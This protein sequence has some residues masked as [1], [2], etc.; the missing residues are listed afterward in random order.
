MN[1]KKR[2]LLI[3]DDPN[4]RAMAS[5]ILKEKE[6]EVIS[7]ATAREAKIELKQGHFDLMI[8][9]G[10]LPDMD[11][12]SFI[13]EQRKNEVTTPVLFVSASWKDSTSY[14]K[15]SKELGVRSILHKPVIAIVLAQEVDKALG[16]WVP[17]SSNKSQKIAD[18]LEK[19]RVQYTADLV[20]RIDEVAD[21]IEKAK[22][23]R[24]LQ[25]ADEVYQLAHKL[26]GTGASFGFPLISDWMQKIE[27]QIDAIKTGILSEAAI[28]L[29]WKDIETNIQKS[30]DFARKIPKTGALQPLPALPG[31]VSKLTA[32]IV[33]EDAEVE[34]LIAEY[35]NQKDIGWQCSSMSAA[36][37][38]ANSRN[39]DIVFVEAD[40][41]PQ[42]ALSL[43]KELRMMSE[44]VQVPFALIKQSKEH[45]L[46]HQ[47]M[48]AGFDSVL[49]RPLAQTSIHA[50]FHDMVLMR[51]AVLNKV[52][53][54][55]D[56]LDFINRVQALLAFEG[57]QVTSFA[58]TAKILDLI[59]G[60]DPQI[61]L[62]DINMPGLSGF[63][64]C[65]KLRATREWQ[66]LPIIFISGRND[67][68]TRV[69]AFESGG[70]DYLAKP[71]INAELLIKL[72]IWLDRAKRNFAD[73]NK[74]PR[75]SLLNY[76]AFINKMK[77]Q[78]AERKED[79]AV[80]LI[81]LTHVE[82]LNKKF[83]PDIVDRILLCMSDLLRSRF[84]L[85]SIRGRWSGATLALAVHAS[86]EELDLTMVQFVDELQEAI[87]DLLDEDVNLEVSTFDAIE[88]NLNS[89]V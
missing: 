72:K 38:A 44:F 78:Q 71:V 10:I 61:L 87:N 4:F 89:I 13:E 27:S 77:A 66:H 26:K 82:K 47:E 64:I 62:L 15:L 32:L 79:M 6:I 31:K 49:S 81:K 16:L 59:D 40:K 45:S 9:D 23:N 8:V 2:I 57:M 74:D 17:S 85:N 58:D 50:T 3:D 73:A 42:S 75:T 86:K 76:T 25:S 14:H 88:R 53:I 41:D 84:P 83:G 12:L 54:I 19:I 69:A 60:L 65:K 43:T 80:A 22:S 55:D 34:K 11:G 18:K 20:N 29:A 70:D 52:L 35:A 7:A 39:F 24:A 68:E 1:A 37:E 30:I 21:A 67:W 46:F 63:D 5:G 28:S 51:N 48:Y 56:D 36:R 33:S